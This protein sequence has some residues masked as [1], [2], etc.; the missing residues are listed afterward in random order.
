M[1]DLRTGSQN[2]SGEAKQFPNGRDRRPTPTAHAPNSQRIRQS[3]F[4]LT[5]NPGTAD[6]PKQQ[7]AAEVTEYDPHE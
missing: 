4:P 6:H 2:R 3:N 7:A 1:D 5:G